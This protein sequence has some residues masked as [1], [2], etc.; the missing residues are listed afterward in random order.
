MEYLGPI[1]YC[2]RHRAQPVHHGVA[3]LKLMKTRLQPTTLD[4]LK[5]DAVV[6]TL[7]EFQSIDSVIIKQE[8]C[9]EELPQG[10]VISQPFR[11]S[12]MHNHAPRK[13]G[14]RFTADAL[15]QRDGKRHRS[16]DHPGRSGRPVRGDS[17]LGPAKAALRSVL[18]AS[19][20]ECGR[21]RDGGIGGFLQGVQGRLKPS[22][23]RR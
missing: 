7:T 15:F 13:I 11:L 22:R 9:G 12:S 20:A 14:E 23:K 5:S 4:E 16:G 1:R 3:T 6:N 21:R 10:T 19:A 8:G 2:R 18:S 17:L